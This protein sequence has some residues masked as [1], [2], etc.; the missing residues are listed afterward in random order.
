M[1]AVELAKVAAQAEALRLRQMAK[2]QGGRAAYGA[3][4]AAFGIAVLVMLHVLAWH[5]L[6]PHAVGPV[7]GSVILL[8]F[9]AIVAGVC[10]Y[11]ASSST[12]SQ[13]EAEAEG[14]RR[15]AL[16]E[17]RSSLTVPALLLPAGGA[18]LRRNPRMAF[19]A[20][21]AAFRMLRRRRAA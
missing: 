21:S 9:D 8:A 2:R 13:V 7:W 10:G 6:V 4:A 20:G 17:M 1:R 15:Q 18:M 14:I 16:T 3:V 12:P 5:A 11:L 19:K